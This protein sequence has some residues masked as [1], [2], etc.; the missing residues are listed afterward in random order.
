MLLVED[1][2]QIRLTAT[3]ML[4]DLGCKVMEASSAEEGLKALNETAVDIL[5][6][7][8]GLPGVSGLELAKDARTLR[9]DLCI[10][11]ATGDSGIK[12]EAELLDAVLVAKPYAPETLRE[13]LES[14]LKAKNSSFLS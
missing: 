6:T 10:V 12:S 3:E 4:N 14:A 13:G 5:V 2:E 9:P 11:V 8:V 7:D 1:D